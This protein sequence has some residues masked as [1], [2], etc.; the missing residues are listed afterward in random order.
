MISRAVH[1]AEDKL[2][3]LKPAKPARATWYA[4]DYPKGKVL[5]S[6][7]AAHYQ[8]Y[9]PTDSCGK[10]IFMCIESRSQGLVSRVVHG[11]SLRDYLRSQSHPRPG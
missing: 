1:S 7:T 3:D 8:G 6:L 4:Q 2:K 10:I 5:L 11:V 9:N